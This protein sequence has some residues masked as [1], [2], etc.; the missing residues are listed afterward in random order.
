MGTDAWHN[1]HA[2]LDGEPEIENVVDILYSDRAFVGGPI[3]IGPYRLDLIF[4]HPSGGQAAT[5]G[6]AGA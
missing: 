2:F 1:W 5:V 3:S 4:R 6:P